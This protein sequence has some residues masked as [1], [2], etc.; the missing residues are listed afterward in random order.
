M[1]QDMAAELRSRLS[2]GSAVATSNSG[3]RDLWAHSD[4]TPA[5]RVEAGSADDVAVALKV[6]RARGLRVAV[7]GGRY[8]IF[9]RNGGADQLVIDL[10]RLR[11][12]RPLPGAGAVIVGGGATMRDALSGLPDHEVIVTT[13]HPGVG[14]LGATSGGGYGPLNGRYGMMADQLIAAQ[15]VLADGSVVEAGN[16]LLWGL[17]GAGTGFGVVTRATVKTYRLDRVL[18]AVVTVPLPAAVDAL[19]HVQQAIDDEPEKLG[20][21]PLFTAGQDAEPVLSLLMH[22]TGTQEGAERM[23]KPFLSLPGAQTAVRQWVPYAGSFSPDPVVDAMWP[24]GMRW[25]TDTRTIER[26]ERPVA[27]RLTDVARAMPG[28]SLLFLHDLHGVP[29]RAAHPDAAFAL[30]RPHF[31]VMAAG[32]APADDRAVRDR[33]QT[34]AAT[35]P[36]A[37]HG[38]EMP[39]DYINFLAPGELSR[40]TNSF[41]D[42]A[43]RVGR[44]KRKLDPDQL[45][46]GITGV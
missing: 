4:A 3:A 5:L 31:V 11:D 40:A 16:E 35:L 9:G 43:A 34:W 41:G 1:T 39:G 33:Q 2:A 25:A 42:N 29:A 10:R 20:L 17:R 18:H 27:E 44:L 21:M 24:H 7:W 8:D 15:V 28:R 26:L 30:R 13:S 19:L 22:Y 32:H 12:V 46:T 14:V 6:A 37:L 23:V 36:D 45:F 38:H